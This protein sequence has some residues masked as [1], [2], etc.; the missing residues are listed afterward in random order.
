MSATDDELPDLDWEP[1]S[2]VPSERDGTHVPQLGNWR[3]SG[4]LDGQLYGPARKVEHPGSEVFFP[5]VPNGLDYLVSVVEHLESGDERVS[6]RDLKYAVLHLAAG[7]EVLL[8]A[9]LPLEH[10][11]LVFKDPGHRTGR[12][13]T[14]MVE[15][16][17]AA[18]PPTLDLA[19]D[20]N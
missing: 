15:E 3:R 2:E 17:F 7:A 11:S 4:V 5:P 6:A 14:A 19:I 13:P 20:A 16:A 18:V 12:P 8:K 10:W 1:R 9:W